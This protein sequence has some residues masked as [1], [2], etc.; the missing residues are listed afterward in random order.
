M[1]KRLHDGFIHGDCMNIV[2]VEDDMTAAG[3]LLEYLEDED[4][5]VMAV[6]PSGEDALQGLMDPACLPDVVLMDVKLPGISGIETTRALKN[7]YPDLE[8]VV[9]TVFEDSRTIIDAIRA[10][11]SGYILKGTSKDELL[12]AL[13]EVRKGGSFLSG[14]VARQVLREFH[15]PGVTDGN[16]F[17][18]SGREEE[19]LGELVRGASYKEIADSLSI[20]VHTVNNHI[21]KIY[22][23]M[24]VHSRG[25]AAAK[26]TR[27]KGRTAQQEEC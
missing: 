3:L 12:S 5:R 1:K 22:E 8:I 14:R 24:Q 9:Q 13:S 4:N 19:I 2:I 23:K 16:D 25:E 18:L 26:F 17:G 6:Y 7:R 27:Q 11:A 10:G 15:D 21:R 20:S